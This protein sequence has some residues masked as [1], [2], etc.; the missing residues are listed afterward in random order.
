MFNLWLFYLSIYQFMFM[1]FF[2]Y[3]IV[4]SSYFDFSDY[5]MFLMYLVHLIFC[6]FLHILCIRS[7]IVLFMWVWI[8]VHVYLKTLRVDNTLGRNIEFVDTQAVFKTTHLFL[9]NAGLFPF[10]LSEMLWDTCISEYLHK[11]S[12]LRLEVS[13]NRGI[14]FP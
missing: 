7:V 13:S 1:C 5:M 4:Y 12:N 2:I 3:F 10:S 11:D 9:L 14:I 8:Q 6:L